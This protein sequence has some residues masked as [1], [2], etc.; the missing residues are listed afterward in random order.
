MLSKC[1]YFAGESHQVVR[2]GNFWRESD[3]RIIDRFYC[4]DCARTFSRATLHPCFR[5][6]KRR[7]HEPM[8]KLLCSGVSM[9]RIALLLGVNRKT[10]AR[11]LIFLGM[12]ARQAHAQS[13]RQLKKSKLEHIQFD[14]LETSEHTKCKPLSA[15]LAVDFHTRKIL[16]FEIASMPAKGHLAKI[17]RKKYGFRKD[18]R[19]EKLNLM[20]QRLHEFVSANTTFSSDEN[21]M[22]PYVLRAHFKNNPHT[23][24]KSRRGCIAGQGELKKIGM[25]PLFSL[26]HTCAMLRANINRLFRRTWC[27]TKKKEALVHHLYIYAAFHN[28][29][30]TETL[31]A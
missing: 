4:K 28:H 1:P 26:N 24:V 29:T 30:L 14:E 11:K 13:I 27:T 9:R 19:K 2:K 15:P 23:R 31:A 7:I 5:F 21:P 3:S 16:A 17:S 22:Y 20:F 6:K 8:R 10:V 18:E 25:D 12:Q